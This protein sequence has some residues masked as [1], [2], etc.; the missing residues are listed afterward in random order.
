MTWMTYSQETAVCSVMLCTQFNLNPVHWPVP[1]VLAFLRRL[2]DNGK[3]L[4]VLKVHVVAI[5]AHHSAMRSVPLG[6]I[7]FTHKQGALPR[8]QCEISVLYCSFRCPLMSPCRILNWNGLSID[9]FFLLRDHFSKKS[10]R[11]TCLR[12]KLSLHAL[13]GIW[14]WNNFMTQC[15][16]SAQ[17]HITHFC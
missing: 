7:N 8:A 5:A 17:I 10:V 3:S 13:V 4:S 1:K 6:L 15:R 16:V 14:L 9:W 2:L 11:T 12:D